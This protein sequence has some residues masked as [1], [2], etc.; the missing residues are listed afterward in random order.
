[1]NAGVTLTLNNITL[2]NG[3]AAQGG[4]VENAGN[5]VIN[6]STLSGNAANNFGGAIYNDTGATA[7]ISG[8]TFSGNS[9]PQGGGIYNNNGTV[10]ISGSTISGNSTTDAGGFIY[11]N[12]TFT[13]SATTFSGNTATNFG[14][15][16][17]NNLVDFTVSG[18]TF[19]SNSAG[20]GG[21]IA[22]YN[23]IATIGNST[24][25]GNT[26]TGN[27][28]A[29]YNGGTG[30][31]S[32][33]TFSGNS[34]ASGGG[35]YNNDTAN[36][37]NA[38]LANSTGG[39]CG[40]NNLIGG[41]NL[42]FGDNT[43]IN[44]GSAVPIAAQNPLAGGLAN[45]GGSTQTIALSS[46][47]ANPALGGGNTTVCGSTPVNNVDQR[48][49]PRPQPAGTN[50]D[51]GSFETN[52]NPLPVEVLHAS[53]GATLNA[54][55]SGDIITYKLIIRNLDYGRAAYPYVL[56][57]LNS[58][59]ELLSASFPD[60]RDWVKEIV[61][62]GANPHLEIR[63]H[64]LMFKEQAGATL[65]FR[66]RPEVADGQ[67]LVQRYPVFWDDDSGVAFSRY[68]N[69]VTVFRGQEGP[70]LFRF[71]PDSVTIDKGSSRIFAADFF[72]PD[73][74]VEFWYTDADGKS[75]SLGY[76]FADSDGNVKFDLKTADIPPGLYSIAGRGY[77]CAIIAS[78]VITIDG[79][80]VQSFTPGNISV[81]AG[82]TIRLSGDFFGPGERV[83]YWYT[84]PDGES[85][86]LGYVW[87][88]ADGQV[89]IQ[90][91]LTGIPAGDY[92]V[93]AN[94]NR[95]E[96]RARALVKVIVAVRSPGEQSPTNY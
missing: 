11:N 63:F 9:A 70:S 87:A 80:K 16:I 79:T 30:N 18:S 73:E 55:V 67:S 50:C 24:F 28:G 21:A 45:Y 38:L 14:G 53:L 46:G 47:W 1:V 51:I 86:E 12:G 65:L 66:F 60:N 94:G 43:C 34:A 15:A 8:S 5:V 2:T 84:S 81:N 32:N 61:A 20:E 23:G 17:Y 83:T 68:S 40:G 48:G 29:V 39:N 44:G 37:N 27:G 7:T 33:A 91:D 54:S 52:L 10:T 88:D 89:N 76:R 4:A 77:F 49:E 62:E 57:P 59:L 6:N 69:R 31:L 92:V 25:S 75:V 56:F 72:V 96:V 71:N 22:T 41:N 58:S 42:Q 82:E 78:A 90:V 74:K 35:I 93:A 26:A 85:V 95:S 3:L 36:V 64:D 13:A 19:S